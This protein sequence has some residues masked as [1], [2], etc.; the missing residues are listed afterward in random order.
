MRRYNSVGIHAD[1]SNTLQCE[2]FAMPPQQ[3][4]SLFE[5]AG[6]RVH[7]VDDLL[8]FCSQKNPF[9]GYKGTGVISQFQIPSNQV[10]H[11]TEKNYQN[12]V[13]LRSALKTEATTLLRQ[14]GYYLPIMS[15]DKLSGKKLH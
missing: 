14:Q 7:C 15:S 10:H 8:Y 4:A 9:R 6:H 3:N 13:A 11:F 5:G 12:S 2:L 1:K